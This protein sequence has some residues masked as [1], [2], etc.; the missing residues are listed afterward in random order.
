MDGKLAAGGA[1]ARMYVWPAA[2]CLPGGMRALWVLPVLMMACADGPS[3]GA[4]AGAGRADALVPDA[5]VTPADASAPIDGGL[6]DSGTADSGP[7]LV[8]RTHA[9]GPEALDHHA[10]FGHTTAEGAWMYVAGGAFYDGNTRIFGGILRAA[11][12]DRGTPGPWSQI[13]VL[14]FARAAP[15]VVTI[16]RHVILAG[17]KTGASRGNVATPE[18]V[19]LELGERGELVRTTTAALPRASFHHSSAAIGRRVFVAG[20]FD[21]DEAVLDD[22]LTATLAD[23]G[24]LS[25]WR[26]A[27]RLPTPIT[28]GGMIAIDGRLYLVGG[29]EGE[30]TF[31]G[32]A[33]A[34]VGVD[35][36]LGEWRGEAL[37]PQSLTTA[38]LM[39]HDGALYAL[40]GRTGGHHAPAEISR[41]VLRSRV[42]AGGLL[43]V[44]G[45]VAD[46]LPGARQHLHQAVVLRGH[47][48]MYG[49]RSEADRTTDTVWSAALP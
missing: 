4:D 1:G 10:S 40:G 24:T 29:A 36:T 13:G 18:L 14:P 28:L 45:E 33:S 6:A 12:D 26:S 2:C 22:V 17:G 21:T 30:H 5:A 7:L 16:G 41:A 44:W 25:A 38:A 8:W 20:G 31:D 34:E 47:V 19:V 3:V 27:G 46:P 43:G 39:V 15:S 48:L 35:G 23:D 11:V 32:V 42:G 49:G 9:P 37:L